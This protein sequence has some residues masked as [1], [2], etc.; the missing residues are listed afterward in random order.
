M[1]GRLDGKIAIVTG[2]ATGI[3]SATARLFIRRR[4]GL[5]NRHQGPW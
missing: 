2:A 1:T 5:R 4:K 3:G